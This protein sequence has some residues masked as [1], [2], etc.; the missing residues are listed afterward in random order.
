MTMYEVYDGEFTRIMGEKALKGYWL[1]TGNTTDYPTF[2]SWLNE[3][4]K[5]GLAK[6]I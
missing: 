3:L 4:I 6:E 5:L 1:T 2:G